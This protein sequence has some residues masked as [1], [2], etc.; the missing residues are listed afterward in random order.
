MFKF[1]NPNPNGKRVGDCTV[2]AISI[3]TDQDW[4]ETYVGLVIQGFI[5][6]DMPSANDVWGA[7]LLTR[8][9][10]RRAIPNEC[11]NCYTVKNFAYDYPTGKYLLALPSHVVAVIDGDYYDIWDSG[12]EVPLYYWTKK[13]E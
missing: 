13:G 10:M 8:G 6:G 5:M 2:R 1:C 11:P 12:D 4:G 7:Y 3:L 9:F